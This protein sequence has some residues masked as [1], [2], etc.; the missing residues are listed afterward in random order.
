MGEW[1]CIFSCWKCSV[2]TFRAQ[3]YCIIGKPWQNKLYMFT[4]L[5]RTLCY[6]PSR[7]GDVLVFKQLIFLM[8]KPFSFCHFF[9]GREWEGFK[10]SGLE[11]LHLE[12]NRTPTCTCT[13]NSSNLSAVYKPWFEYRASKCWTSTSFACVLQIKQGVH[14]ANMAS[15]RHPKVLLANTMSIRQYSINIEILNSPSKIQPVDLAR[16]YICKNCK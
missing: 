5:K 8:I 12:Q 4:S 11:C 14:L 15:K 2:C 3:P 16:Q 1:R 7:C 13:W 9:R 6:F 10:R